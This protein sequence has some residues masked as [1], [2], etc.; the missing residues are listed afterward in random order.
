[1]IT[2][3]MLPESHAR[4]LPTCPGCGKPKQLGCIVCWDCF[5]YRSDITPLKY[6]DGS[7]VDWLN[8]YNIGLLVPI[9]S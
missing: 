6:Y 8:E 1:M 3:Q 2:D 9:V 5:K 7:L 4:A